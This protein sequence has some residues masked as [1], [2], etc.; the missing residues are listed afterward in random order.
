MGRPS[1]GLEEFLEWQ[2]R[3]ESCKKSDL[4]VGEFCLREGVSRST[5]YRWKQRLEDGIPASLESPAARREQTEPRKPLFVPVSVKSS[6]VV[7][8]ELPNGGVL[9]FPS[10]V[11]KSVLVSV[12][13]VVGSLR[14]WRGPEA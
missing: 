4:D 13:K 9:R 2:A 5:F 14:P 7:E 6:H 8:M 10:D 12:V 1:S 11:G 3:L